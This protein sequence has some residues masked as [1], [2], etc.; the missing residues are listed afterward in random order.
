MPDGVAIESS[1]NQIAVDSRNFLQSV[2]DVIRLVVAFQI[3]FTIVITLIVFGHELTFAQS[4]LMTL[5]ALACLVW[6]AWK[7]QPLIYS[8]L[9]GSKGGSQ[10]H[11]DQRPTLYI[12]IQL[13]S[14][15]A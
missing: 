9:S 2:L 11:R 7:A 4:M 15:A 3:G 5:F 13:A 10:A 1:I 14:A 6:T 12:T 8:K